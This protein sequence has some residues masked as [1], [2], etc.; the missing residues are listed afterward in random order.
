[1]T[2]KPKNEFPKVPPFIIDGTSGKATLEPASQP[3]SANRPPARKNGRP[4]ERGMLNV[5]I[6]LISSISLG[7]AMMGGA[8]IGFGV[9]SEGVANQTN[10]FP[11]IIVVGLAYLVGWIVSLF[12]VRTLG[13]FLLP[14]F[15][16]TYAWITLAGI[17]ILQIAII[18]KLFKQ[19]YSAP[20][21]GAYLVMY[22]AGILALIG[23]HLIIEK[24][25]LVPFS[26]P[27]LFI[28]LAHLYLIVFH[29]IFVPEE[30]V[31]YEFLWG[32]VVFFI[33][34]TA[35]SILM[36]AHFGMLNGLR[37][38]IDSAFSKNDNIFVPPS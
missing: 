36:L 2:D 33:A 1:M 30:R 37:K 27:L 29:Y 13:N 26:F 32:D 6:L 10:L 9:L 12:G 22:A 4:S 28:S 15:I 16:K 11:K 18:S 21:F 7:I 14:F 8:W 17:C 35:V 25:N 23:L 31:K 38:R 34:T 24:H 3:R 5:T 20:K 19:A